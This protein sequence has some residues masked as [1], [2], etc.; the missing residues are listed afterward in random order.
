MSLK[1]GVHHCGDIALEQTRCTLEVLNVGEVGVMNTLA[2]T[3]TSTAIT[4][5]PAMSRLARQGREI[6]EC[7]ANF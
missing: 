4:G 6:S 1:C 2:L 3:V 5:L 7:R